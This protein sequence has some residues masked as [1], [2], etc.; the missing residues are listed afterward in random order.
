[1]ARP[2]R[3]PTRSHSIRASDEWDRLLLHISLPRVRD[4]LAAAYLGPA[5][6]VTC[7]ACAGAASALAFPRQAASITPAPP[8]FLRWAPAGP[9]GGLVLVVSFVV[10]V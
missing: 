3:S 5:W 7:G 2:V 1:M 8:S 9:P 6:V 10:A 4:P